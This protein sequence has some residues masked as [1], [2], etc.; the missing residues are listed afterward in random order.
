MDSS[1]QQPIGYT[2]DLTTVKK[3]PNRERLRSNRKDVSPLDS[4]STE[5]VND[6][7]KLILGMEYN[8]ESER[9][10]REG[11]ENRNI[12]LETEIS[13][14]RNLLVG[15]DEQKHVT[16]LPRSTRGRPSRSTRRRFPPSRHG[17]SNRS[18]ITSSSSTPRMKR[19]P[20]SSMNSAR[21][22]R[23]YGRRRAPIGSCWT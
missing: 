4:L 17:R 19:S 16:P 22:R 11:L 6:Y 8:L 13:N 12:S 9:R 18:R 21:C 1:R 2:E 14:L 10:K 3:H 5:S 7:Q 20:V 15:P 23:S